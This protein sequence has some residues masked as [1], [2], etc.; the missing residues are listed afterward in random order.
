MPIYEFYCADCHTIFNFFSRKIDT[1]SRPDCPRCGRKRLAREVSQFAAPKRGAGSDEGGGMD[2]LP[3]DES[4]M[5]RAMS[6]LASDAERIG[7]DDPRQAAQLMRKFS[8]LTGL[9]FNG[10]MEQAINRLESGEDPEKIEQE[11]GG[12]MEGDEQPF[13]LPGGKGAKGRRTQPPGRDSKLYD[14]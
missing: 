1:S 2:D 8:K 3:I 5:E 11:M 12:L 4:K 10:N 7:D 14:L 13:V 6:E 9:E